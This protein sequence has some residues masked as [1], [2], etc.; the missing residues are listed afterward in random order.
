MS[1][2]AP[3][4]TPVAR[5][6]AAKKVC[7]RPGCSRKPPPGQRYCKPCRNKYMRDWRAR[8]PRIPR[9]RLAELEALADAG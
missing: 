1:A 5:A 7:S 8:N 9:E 3:T 4:F 6:I 2:K